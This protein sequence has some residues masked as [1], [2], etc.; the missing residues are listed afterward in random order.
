MLQAFKYYGSHFTG[1]YDFSDECG[2][3]FLI[4]AGIIFTQAILHFVFFFRTKVSREL[5][6]DGQSYTAK[7][8]LPGLVKA[9]YWITYRIIPCILIVLLAFQYG[10]ETHE[11]ARA[12]QL[13]LLT[14]QVGS[15]I[16]Y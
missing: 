6:E 16:W 11:A 9:N 15:L 14:A 10:F 5:S 8:S 13:F 3:M 2:P 1:E 4:M 7:W 12:L